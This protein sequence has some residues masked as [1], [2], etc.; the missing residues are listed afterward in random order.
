MYLNIKKAVY[1][2]PIHNIGKTENITSKVRNKS[3]VST[4]STLIQH[5][6]GILVRALRQEEEIKGIKIEK[7]EVKLPLFEM[8]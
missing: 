2:K 3:R 6:S 5:S 4:L 7:E 8:T 1:S